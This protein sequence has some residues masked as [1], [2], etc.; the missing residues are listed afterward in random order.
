MGVGG[1][2]F[3][4]T[5]TFLSLPFG[6][7]G[8]T[9]GTSKRRASDFKILASGKPVGLL[10]DTFKELQLLDPENVKNTKAVLRSLDGGSTCA[11]KTFQAVLAL[12]TLRKDASVQ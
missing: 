11:L 6:A 10:V 4:F 9:L 3:C 12:T 8:F 2:E 7:A 1:D 5:D